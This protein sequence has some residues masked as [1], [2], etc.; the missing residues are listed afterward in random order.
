MNMSVTRR[1]SHI[2][3]EESLNNQLDSIRDDVS[4]DVFRPKVA[5][6][7]K[8]LDLAYQA[9]EEEEREQK[10]KGRKKSK[11]TTTSSIKSTVISWLWLIILSFLFILFIISLF[12]I[13]Y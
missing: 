12:K 8:I 11:V 7:D 9:M 4:L 1:K 5:V 13:L 10:G 2:K 6:E 3:L